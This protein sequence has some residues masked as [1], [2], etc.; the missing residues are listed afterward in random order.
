VYAYACLLHTH[1][2]SK[3]VYAYNWATHAGPMYVYAYSCPETLI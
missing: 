2:Y 3:Y 1:A